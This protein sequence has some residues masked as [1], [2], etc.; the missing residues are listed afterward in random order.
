MSA[1]F[2]L[3][4]L[5]CAP[6]GRKPGTWE[7]LPLHPDVQRNDN[8]APLLTLVDL[9][10]TGYL[11]FSAKWAAPAAG[12]DALREE[13]AR[14]T[15]QAPALVELSFAQLGEPRCNALLGDGGGRFQ[16]VATSTTSGSPPY[17]AVFNLFL[18]DEDL[19]R[20]KAGL[21]GDPGYLAI[22]YAAQHQ[23]PASAAA[24]FHA[25]AATLRPWLR[26][27]G[28]DLHGPRQL[29][30]RAVAQG[31]ASITIDAPDDHVGAIATD[32]YDR[33]LDQVARTLPRWLEDASD[34]E[35]HVRV[36]LE[37]KL[38]EPIRAFADIGAIAAAAARATSGGQDAA[39]R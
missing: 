28:A 34:G 23:L 26:A 19:D 5:R 10:T 12:L 21:R 6:V 36:T 7:F 18:Q 30:E 16:S 15:G 17:N 4:G 33:V 2:D 32:L 3:H 38:N 39:D 14:R 13:I 11:M 35:L 24:S 20:A 29:L 31:Q 1:S 8:G 9:G 22:E 25:H 37:Q 27:H